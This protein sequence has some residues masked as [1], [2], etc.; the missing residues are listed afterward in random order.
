VRPI[1]EAATN[2]WQ[3]LQIKVKE[4]K[5]A[6][7]RENRFSKWPDPLTSNVPGHFAP[8]PNELLM[9][10]VANFDQIFR[11]LV[12]ETL[13]T[14]LRQSPAN[15]MDKVASKVILGDEVVPAG[16]PKPGFTL[17]TCEKSWIPSD[18]LMQ[19]GSLT[20]AP[21]AA[22]YTFSDD[23]EVYLTRARNWLNLDGTAFGNYLKVTLGEYLA[24]NGAPQAELTARRNTFTVAMAEVLKRSAPL[25]QINPAVLSAI[26][27]GVQSDDNRLMFSTVPFAPNSTM[28]D[29]FKNALSNYN[30]KDQKLTQA[31]SALGQSNAQNIDVFTF[32]DH[33]LNPMVYDSIMKPIANQWKGTTTVDGRT[34]FWKWRRARPLREFIPADPETI[35]QMIRGWFIATA[36]GN[37]KF[38][39]DSS[40]DASNNQG[41][42][43][44][45]WSDRYGWK[46]FPY[47]LLYPGVAP[48]NEYLGSVLESLAIAIA[49]CN[50]SPV[51]P[52][53]PLIP[54][55]RL[56]DLGDVSQE[57][58]LGA[59]VRNGQ[60]PQGA[61]VPAADRAGTQSGTPDERKNALIAFFD[62]QIVNYNK[63]FVA[64]EESGNPYVSQRNWE[65]K[66]YVLN[67]LDLLKQSIQKIE[68]ES[69]N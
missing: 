60:L 41:P 16:E 4:Q 43:I 68:T 26:H 11:T 45:I 64:Y 53:E 52:L 2:G 38:E 62:R 44:E 19:S 27:P 59:W 28:A 24:D 49:Q 40:S 36:I 58:Q 30:I 61:P 9:E 13:P 12:T 67:S 56:L 14:D 6:D 1:T 3:S 42:K 23:V 47:P 66:G 32:Q 51:N 46:S 22:R 39:V 35:S 65:L 7:G 69:F 50:T 10:N 15:D 29:L 54:Y 55:H 63:L 57:T 18:H 8:P 37:F 17:F 33:P 5:L 34:A 31:M 21:S 20:G 25:I 48:E